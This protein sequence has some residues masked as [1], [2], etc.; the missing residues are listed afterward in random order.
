VL[1][2]VI[3]HWDL[4]P[5]GLNA[6]PIEGGKP[7]SPR[8]ILLVTLGLLGLT[9]TTRAELTIA[10]GGKSDYRIVIPHEAIPSERYAAEE[11]KSYLSKITGASLPIVDNRAPRTPHEIILGDDPTTGTAVDRATLG[12][13]GYVLRTS[14]QSLLIT[15]GRPRGTL[16]GVYGLLEDRLG[17]R[18]FAP[19]VESVPKCGKLTLPALNETHVPALEYREVYWSEMIQDADFAARHRQNGNSYNLTAKHGGRAV[20]Y[21]PFVHSLDML[22]PRNLFKDHPEY[23]PLIGGQRKGGYV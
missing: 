15:G 16:Y 21:F 2:P 18:W 6:H 11:L 9:A 14:G 5:T 23:F 10:E 13:D 12:T 22:V 4:P 19:M 20:V 7:M 17:V 3:S 1:S 8:T